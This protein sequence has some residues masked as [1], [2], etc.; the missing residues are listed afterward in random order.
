MEYK[1]DPQ[2]FGI[3]IVDMQTHFLSRL[4][5]FR[6]KA[7]I[8]SHKQLI[9]D[10]STKNIPIAILEYNGSGSTHPELIKSLR[11]NQTYEF[12]PKYNDGGFSGTRNK[13]KD[14]EVQ[15]NQW[16]LEALCITGM[17]A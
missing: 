15:L 7:I 6:E 13:P 14:L 11:S 16:N 10:C 8:K 4:P 3:V 5:T 17:E 2:T 1:I 12:L 9:K